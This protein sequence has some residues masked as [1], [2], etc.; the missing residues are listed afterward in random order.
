MFF[1]L[2]YCIGATI[3]TRQE[4]QCLP[5]AGLFSIKLKT[6]GFLHLDVRRR[7]PLA[8]AFLCA[9]KLNIFKPKFWTSVTLSL[10][11][12]FNFV[13]QTTKKY[14]LSFVVFGDTF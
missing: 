14:F 11:K 9:F 2:F 1:L 10:S 3:R 6:Y 7:Q 5:Y 4:S 12:S 8:Q 13:K